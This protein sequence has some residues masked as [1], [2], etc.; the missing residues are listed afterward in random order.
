MDTQAEERKRLVD[1]LAAMVGRKAGQATINLKPA[2]RKDKR[3]TA[4]SSITGFGV[5]TF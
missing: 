4:R 5:K 1:N 2:R 3:D